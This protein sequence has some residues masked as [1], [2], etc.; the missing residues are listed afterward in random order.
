MGKCLYVFLSRHDIAKETISKLEDLSIKTFK[1]EIERGKGMEKKNKT[2]TFTNYETTSK[3][4]ICLTE[5]SQ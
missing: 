4:V 1:P 3:G 5:I 2:R